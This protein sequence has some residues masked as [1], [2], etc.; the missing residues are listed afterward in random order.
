MWAVKWSLVGLG[1]TAVLQLVVAATTGSVAVLA[2]TVHNLGDAA[3]AIPLWIAF[4]LARLKPTP[5]FTYGYGRA[6]DLAGVAVVVAVLLSA[7]FAAYESIHRFLELQEVQHLWAVALAGAI[8]FAGNE[9]VARLRINVG[10]EIGSAALEAD[11]QHARADSLTSLAVIAGA[12]GIALGFPM[13][14]P[15][16]GLVI[17]VMILRI[18][19][20]SIK[21]VFGRLLDG[22]DPEVVEEVR[23]VTGRGRGVEDVTEVRVRWFGHRLLAE[24]N[25][26]VSPELHVHDAHDIA[27]EVE[28]DLL[29]RLPYLS[30][31]TIHI[32]SKDHSGEGHHRV[33]EHAHGEHP[34]HSH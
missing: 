4:A 19:W 33:G 15:I 34:A 11:G 13:A 21:A 26:A 27:Q 8:G 7:A 14:D 2:D 10:K 28:H 31:A 24:V 32:D 30:Q 6:E 20:G 12:A 29:H 3:T 17:S 5:R 18:A 9:A 16:A 1:L 23:E 25:L 22:V